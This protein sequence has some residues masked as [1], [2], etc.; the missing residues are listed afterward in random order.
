MNEQDRE[1]NQENRGNDE[2]GQ[3][4]PP[5]PPLKPIV[6]TSPQ[7]AWRP[8]LIIARRGLI[9]LAWLVAL[10]VGWQSVPITDLLEGTVRGALAWLGTW[11]I[12][13]LGIQLV[14]RILTPSEH[15]D[16]TPTI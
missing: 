12:G 4:D 10:T 15:T 9:F 11:L 16:A 6:L 1:E 8:A 2:P 5:K 14:E 3:E 7:E 13:N